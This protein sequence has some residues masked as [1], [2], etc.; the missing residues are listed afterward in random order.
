[1]TINRIRLERSR[2]RGFAWTVSTFFTLILFASS[3]FA[4]TETGQI[5]GKVIDPNGA[6][7]PGATISI[8]SVDT[9]REVSATADDNGSYTVTALQP[10]PYEVTAQSHVPNE[11]RSQ[12][13]IGK[14]QV[15]VAD[16]GVVNITV[17]LSPPNRP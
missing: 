12:V 9:G 4:Q 14:Q 16:S 7:V 2:L 6:I 5:K 11:P 15:T 8:K 3:S 1:M 13:L 10:G 17:T